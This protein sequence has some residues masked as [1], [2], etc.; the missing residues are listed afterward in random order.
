MRQVC[1]RCLALTGYG[2][3]RQLAISASTTAP[4]AHGISSRP[5]SGSGTWFFRGARLAGIGGSEATTYVAQGQQAKAANGTINRELAMLTKMLRLAFE[6][7]KLLR[8]PVIRKL[9]QSAP[10]EGFFEREQF[11]EVR[12]R[13]PEDLQ[14]AVR[15]A[16]AL[17]WRMQSEVLSLQRRQ[18]DL[19]AGTL[20]LEPGTTKND[21][22]R[23]V[24]F[25]GR[26][27]AIWS[28]GRGRAGGNAGD[29]TPDA[30]CV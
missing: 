22:G 5:R 28:S 30:F 26:Q 3:T 17:G 20:R 10:R 29:R 19:E 27:S 13:L 2:T 7:G 1:Q 16:Y 21:E 12:R 11:Q 18:V 25:A 24:T 15:L 23:V 9:R 14:V 6:N 8:L 4:P